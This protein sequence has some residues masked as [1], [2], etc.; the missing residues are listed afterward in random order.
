MLIDF[1]TERTLFS[2]GESLLLAL[3]AYILAGLFALL[4]RLLGQ[5][6]NAKK[7]GVSYPKFPLLL[8]QHLTSGIWAIFFF[9][10][11]GCLKGPLHEE[12]G[13]SIKAKQSIFAGGL[14]APLCGS[15]IWA[16]IHSVLAIYSEVAT[17]QTVM[18]FT[19][20][21]ISAHL[22]LTLFTVLPLPGSDAERLLRRKEFSPR[23]AAFRRQGTYPFLIFTVIGLL[24]ACITLPVGTVNCS[25]SG[26]ITLFPV[27]VIGG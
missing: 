11:T 25:L 27:F 12:E 17:V 16:M 4:L 8:L 15:V 1:L 26:L 13:A 18:L 3:T 23:R 19:S 7:N 24:L 9:V 10:L 22:S 20:A 2:R 6:K 14:V 21:M 5:A